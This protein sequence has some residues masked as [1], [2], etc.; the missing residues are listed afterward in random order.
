L[1]AV[2]VL[3]AESYGASRLLLREEKAEGAEQKP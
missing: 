1:N 3:V 2:V